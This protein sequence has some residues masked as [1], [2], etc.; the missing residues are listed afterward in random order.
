MT[1]ERQLVDPDAETG[2]VR[3]VQQRPVELRSLRGDRF[4]KEALGGKAVRNPR[5]ALRQYLRGV[6]SGRDSDRSVERAREIRGDLVGDLERR[7]DASDL[8]ELHGREVAG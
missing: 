3:N 8:G 6:G 4:R 1:G 7:C 2:L 5:A